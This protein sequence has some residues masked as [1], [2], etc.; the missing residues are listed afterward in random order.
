M[1]NN[2]L[3]KINIIGKVSKILLI[4]ACVAISIAIVTSI[5]GGVAVLML[6]DGS[7]K[8]KGEA[9]AEL[10]I[11]YE[12]AP[13]LKNAVKVDEFDYDMFG[14]KLNI[15]EKDSS[16]NEQIISFDGSVEE[17]DMQDFRFVFALGLFTAALLTSGLLIAA[18][19]ATKFAAAIAVCQ[20]PFE[21]NVIRRMKHF[22]FSLIPWALL[23][24]INGSVALITAVLV[25][26]VVLLIAYIFS[27]GANLQQESDDTI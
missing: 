24:F 11:D 6:P 9:N 22:G 23:N 15:D 2:N 3:K 10:I 1:K 18:I 14:F 19:F 7:V 12:T 5:I 20:T 4:I 27:Y 13:I 8:V 21:V 25:V 26:L 16:D 17:I